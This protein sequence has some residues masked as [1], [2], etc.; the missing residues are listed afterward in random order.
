MK[1]DPHNPFVLFLLGAGAS[2]GYIPTTNELTEL[3]INNSEIEIKDV[4]FIQDLDGYHSATGVSY[5]KK[6]SE[7]VLKHKGVN[8]SFEELI[9]IAGLLDA[10]SNKPFNINRFYLKGL[11]A[12]AKDFAVYDTN[13]QNAWAT[14]S[15]YYYIMDKI[16]EGITRYKPEQIKKSG[17]CYLLTSLIEN[18]YNLHV[19]SLNYDSLPTFSGIDF[20][21]GF[22][23]TEEQNKF[24]F[25]RF[26]PSEIMLKNK[27]TNLFCQL[28]GS[29]LFGKIS[30]KK[31]SKEEIVMFN[32]LGS[33]FAYRK[34]GSQANNYC[35]PYK[36]AQDG[37]N[38]PTIPII[39]SLRKADDI[40]FE[41]FGTYMQS[42]F[43]SLLYTPIWVVVGYGGNDYHINSYIS[44]A[45]RLRAE[46]GNMPL[47]ID[48]DFLNGNEQESSINE[49]HFMS[50]I[51]PFVWPDYEKFYNYSS[52]ND[53]IKFNNKKENGL[54][55]VRY[56]HQYTEHP[57]FD[58][59]FC[60]DGI[61]E[62]S[63]KSGE[64]FKKW[65]KEVFQKLT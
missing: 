37:Y 56:N 21:T 62:F 46:I 11:V 31:T 4:D 6:L 57:I 58:I 9:Y 43:A 13:L 52:K 16:Y 18:G 49:K 53:K 19:Y 59:L 65:K 7:L 14:Q 38:I 60:F 33:S 40:L 3:L 24:I 30:F 34:A 1:V 22:N 12:L 64:I 47:I 20:N 26:S 27:F 23:K 10:V 50:K 45:L 61:N 48:V 55:L 44:R 41:P 42:F 63:S 35:S 17:I 5:F 28:H 8:Y 39:T 54:N 51:R 32:D 2:D 25:R 29:L 15:A 36:E